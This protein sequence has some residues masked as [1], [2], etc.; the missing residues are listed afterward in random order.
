MIGTTDKSLLAE[1]RFSKQHG[2]RKD[3]VS[4]G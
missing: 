4:A 3:G 1:N 2:Q